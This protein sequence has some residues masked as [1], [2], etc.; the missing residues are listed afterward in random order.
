MSRL[1][2]FFLPGK[3]GSD[4]E[5][6]RGTARGHRS[7]SPGVDLSKDLREWTSAGVLGTVSL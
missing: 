6:A 2:N 3:L 1:S 7:A 4:A 5:I